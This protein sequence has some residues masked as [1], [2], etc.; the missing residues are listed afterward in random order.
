MMIE[1]SRKLSQIMNTRYLSGD[2]L[3]GFCN[4]LVD[5]FVN[6]AFNEG[7]SANANFNGFREFTL[8]HKAIDPYLT[9]TSAALDFLKT[10]K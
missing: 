1:S 3:A 6:F 5:P 10:N 7:N 8:G 2:L 4:A 9:V